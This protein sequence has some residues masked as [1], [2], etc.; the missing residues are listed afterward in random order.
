MSPEVSSSRLRSKTIVL[1]RICYYIGQTAYTVIEP[2]MINP[3]AWN[4]K[5]KTG[6]FWFGTAIVTLVWG[7]FRLPETGGRTY[8]EMDLMFA[9]KVSTRRNEAFQDL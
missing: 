6:F 8:E 5:G 2:Y 3:V 9:R 4:W 1:A 7:Y